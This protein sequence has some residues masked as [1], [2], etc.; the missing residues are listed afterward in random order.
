MKKSQDSVETRDVLPG[1]SLLQEGLADYHSAIDAYD[2]L[3]AR[4]PNT[5]LREEVLF[6]LY[7]CYTKLGDQTNAD[8]ILQ[9]MKQAFPGGKF[10]ATAINPDSAAQAFVRVRTNATLQ[11][12][13]IYTSFIEGR[14]DEALLEKHQAD[15]L[16]GSAYWTPQLLYIEAV[17]FIH[18]R[19]DR[20][21]QGGAQQY[22]DEVP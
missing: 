14:F 20:R 16:Y 6:N 11:Y 15:S 19:Q 2:S 18:N 22:R 10:T 3:L 5:A 13:K 7:Y 8:H 17:Y 1:Q 12:E 4:I 9:L 21:G